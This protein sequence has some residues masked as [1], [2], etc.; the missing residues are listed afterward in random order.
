MSTERGERSDG[1]GQ[2]WWWGAVTPDAAMDQYFLVAP[3]KID[4]IVEA[5]GVAAG[6]RV[7]ELGAGVGTVAAA[8]PEGTAMTL[9][10]ADPMLAAVLERRFPDADVRCADALRV[11]DA[12]DVL[13]ANLPGFL[14]GRLLASLPDRRFRTAV[15][16]LP[17]GVAP[18]GGERLGV[19]EADD[20]R[21]AAEESSTLWVL[22]R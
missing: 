20:F 7:L 18:D 5:A 10:D 1:V 17:D 11:T 3:E 4:A 22:R 8:L 9:V 12:C 6:D 2:D 15:L 16:A 13:L 19:L 21:P 14:S